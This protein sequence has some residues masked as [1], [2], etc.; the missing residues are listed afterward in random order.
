M[1]E[2]VAN[3]AAILR[4]PIASELEKVMHVMDIELWPEEE[5]TFEK[6]IDT[7]HHMHLKV[8]GALQKLI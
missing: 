6:D 7:R 4:R 3:H 5:S 8:I 2:R 1:T